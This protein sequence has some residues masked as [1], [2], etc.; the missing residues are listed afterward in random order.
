MVRRDG[1]PTVQLV[2]GAPPAANDADPFDGVGPGDWGDQW[3]DSRLLRLFE[4]DAQAAPSP[5]L[6][7]LLRRLEASLERDRKG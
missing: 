6:A 3:I 2:D 5:R 1:R 7:E 4:A